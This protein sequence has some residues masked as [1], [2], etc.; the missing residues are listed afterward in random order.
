[1]TTP[2]NKPGKPP[3]GHVLMT[4]IVLGSLWGVAEVVLGG[5]LKAWGVSHR[6]G[7]LTGVGMGIMGVGLAIFVGVLRKPLM[8][9][10]IA[11]VAVLCKQLVV[12]VLHVSVMCKANSCLAVLLQGS[13]LAGVV[14]VAGRRLHGSYLIQTVVA[15]S[16]AL[17]ARGAFHLA[18]TK[19]APCAYLLSFSRAGGF[20]DYMAAN[21][22]AWAGFS[23]LLFPLGCRLGA[24]LREPVLAVGAARPA[25]YYSS[26]VAVTALCWVASGV[27]ISLGF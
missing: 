24:R 8:L 22:L 26:S 6:A 2:A 10:G 15:A 9:L 12:P 1:M 7:I 23:A 21:G 13:A 4:I 18:G 27:A 11:L 16:A 14:A 3:V 19:L 20:V 17:V 25:L 5:A